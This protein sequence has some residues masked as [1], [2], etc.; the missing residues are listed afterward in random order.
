MPNP[1]EGLITRQ[2]I[3][4][5]AAR[6]RLILEDEDRLSILESMRS[7]DIQACPGSGKTTLI[8]AK[9]I[10][11]AQ[12]WPFSDRGVCVLSHTNVAKNEIVDRLE[13][14]KT[15]QAQ[16]LLSYPHF[17]GTIQEFINRFLSLPYLRSKGVRNITVDN[18]EYVKE[19]RRLL[20]RQQF[21]WFRRTL[22]G[23]GS[24]EHQEGFLRGTFRLG[25]VDGLEININKRPRAWNQPANFQRAQNALGQLKQYLDERGFYLYRDMY[26]QA[27]IIASVNEQLAP[28]I[29]RRFP[30]IFLD[31]MQDTQHFQDDLLLRIF[32]LDDPAVIAQRFGDPDQAIFHGIGGEEPNASFN[33]KSSTDMDFVIN[34]SHRFDDG[35]A[36]KIRGLSFNQVLLETEITEDGLEA[37]KFL[38]AN[39]QSFEHTAFIYRDENIRAVIPAFAE[40]VTSQFCEMYKQSDNFSVKIVGAVGNEIDP[41][42]SQLK[43]GHFW[44][45]FDKSKAKTNFK[46]TTLLEAVY[47]CRQ[48]SVDDWATNYKLLTDCVLKIL[49]RANKRDA[50]G[51]YFGATTMREFLKQKNEWRSFREL[52]YF[53]LDNLQRLDQ[54]FWD[55]GT[56]VLAKIFELDSVPAEVS[57]YLAFHDAEEYVPN[58]GGSDE[59]EEPSL[60][61][62]PENMIQHPDGFNIQISTIHGVKGETHDATLVLE[63]KYFCLDLEAMMPYLTGELPS[64]EHLNTDL[65]PS[66]S[67]AAFKP[68][69]RFMRQLYVA[70]SR[71]KHLLCLAVHSDRISSHRKNALE[72]RGW[73]LH[74]LP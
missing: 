8:A 5:L 38:H 13:N 73:R 61:S 69:Q 68:N 58:M 30:Y 44:P 74:E 36:E 39:V 28:S 60:Q 20:G 10:L 40:L 62:I 66:P 32:P 22:N 34:R 59:T 29:S 54:Q 19:A 14:A 43:I 21:S 1:L 16:R 4:D 45:A 63:T 26:T 35:I 3:A 15:I 42:V 67:R 71:P 70:M 64:N 6:E 51:K 25:T 57:D 27:Q 53:M 31:E 55:A 18:D 24:Q 9:L 47:Y 33:G 11:L 52:I 48:A 37:R 72:D 56:L 49:R 23:L 7:I 2:D 41:N 46:E 65:R 50:E 12:K 17:I